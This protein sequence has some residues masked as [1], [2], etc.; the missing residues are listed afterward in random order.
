MRDV[1]NAHEG[2]LPI[3]FCSCI[4]PRNEE[5]VAS[6]E[7]APTDAH[8][9]HKSRIGAFAEAVANMVT[10][11]TMTNMNE[12]LE[13]VSVARDSDMPVAISFLVETDGM[14]SMGH[15]SWEAIAT[16]DDATDRYA[17]PLLDQ[18]HPPDTFRK[19]AGREWTLPVEISRPAYQHIVIV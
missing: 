17:A 6:E 4:G 16:I 5:Y 10:A 7:I 9:Y 18:L 14:F 15:P 19:Q 12:A 3:V 11:L 8:A 1:L 13:I 2:R